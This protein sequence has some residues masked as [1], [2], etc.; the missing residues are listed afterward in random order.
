MAEKPTFHE[1]LE[2]LMQ[3][4]D[5]YHKLMR[6]FH[7]EFKKTD[8]KSYVCFRSSCLAC[9]RAL[10]CSLKEAMTMVILQLADEYAYRKFDEHLNDIHEPLL[11]LVGRM[12]PEEVE[13]DY[14]T[15]LDE[16]TKSVQFA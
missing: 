9:D 13:L 10:E 15:T 4:D 2:N 5:A 8:Q 16:V 7:K 12:I 1:Y 14:E 6:L 11:I 3:N